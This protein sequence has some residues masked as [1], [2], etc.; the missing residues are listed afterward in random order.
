VVTLT[1]A[2][3]NSITI[4]QPA[5]TSAMDKLSI[6]AGSL[7]RDL[8]HGGTMIGPEWTTRIETALG[9]VEAAAVVKAVETSMNRDG[10]AVI[11]P[12]RIDP[13]QVA[14]YQGVADSNGV[15][16]ESHVKSVFD[17]GFEQGWV[18]QAAPEV[19]KI[20]LTSEQFRQLQQMFEKDS[21]TGQDVIDRLEK[22]GGG[23]EA[24]DHDL[25]LDEMRE[26]SK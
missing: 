26:V 13:T 3:A 22:L 20:L 14:F 12:W 15:S 5:G 17:Y 6:S 9:T 8:A 19:F 24:E 16:L 11:V 10:D 1:D 21:P 7:L 23:F 18:S 25:I 2:E 4:A